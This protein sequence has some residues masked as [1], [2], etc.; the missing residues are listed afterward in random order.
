M[1]K[2][3]SIDGGGIRGIIPAMVLS[4]IEKRTG[5]PIAC[6]FDLIAGTSTG[7]LLALGLTMPD[8]QGKP[9]YAA[10]NLVR[11]YEEKGSKIFSR[12]CWYRI[13]SLGHLADYKYPADGVKLVFAQYFGEACLKDV[14]SDVLLTAYEIELRC[15]FFFRSSRA[16]KIPGYDYPLQDVALATSAAPTYFAPAK[17]YIDGG[18][19]YYALIDGGVFANNPAM[20]AYV[21]ASSSHPGE[22]ILLVSLGTGEQKIPLS[23][24][25]V[26]KWGLAGWARPLLNVVFD[27]VSDTVDYQL[28]SLLPPTDLG[29]L[30]Y[31]RLQAEMNKECKLDDARAENIRLLKRR[32][33]KLI[34]DNSRILD[35]MC[36]QLLTQITS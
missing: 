36:S 18:P 24:E 7:G 33:Q 16:R 30:R 21:E 34:Q 14:L 3:L 15:P 19:E 9:K 20:C 32:A 17:I 10:H 4:E 5:R 1:I 6:L 26:G 31:Y 29:I 35:M 22:D 28:C 25:E 27:G 23:Y 8:P 13:T 12:S 11:L 2:I